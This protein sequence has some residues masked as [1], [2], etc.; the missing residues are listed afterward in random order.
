M[1]WG[2]THEIEGPEKLLYWV[3]A[4]VV[5]Q[6]VPLDHWLGP[7]LEPDGG[8]AGDP[9][10]EIDHLPNTDGPDLYKVWADPEISG[11][12]PSEVVFDARQFS[13]ALKETLLAFRTEFPERAVEVNDVIT[14]C[15]L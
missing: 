7:I 12:E 9:G 11:I 10:W 15:C 1:K 13:D 2:H 5:T 6:S 8:L 3:L 4:W 14:R